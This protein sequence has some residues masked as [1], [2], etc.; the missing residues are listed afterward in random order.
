MRTVPGLGKIVRPDPVSGLTFIEILLVVMILLVIAGLAL[1]DFSRGYQ[2][3]LL[4]QEA[5]RVAALMR[6]AQSRAVLDG[7]RTRLVVQIPENEYWLEEDSADDSLAGA[8]IVPEA[9]E[10]LSGRWGRTERMSP[11][12]TVL[13]SAEAIHF[14]PD[15][16]IDPG[17]LSFCRGERCLIVTT[18]MQRGL[19]LVVQPQKEEEGT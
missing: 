15:G 9:F 11:E 5:G 16:Q 19:I 10:R 7:R 12:M 18:Q 2:A 3:L 17:Q 4:Q 6:Y 8:D 1:P 13:A 14:F